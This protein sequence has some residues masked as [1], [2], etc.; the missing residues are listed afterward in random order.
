MR[1]PILNRSEQGG[2]QDEQKGYY[3]GRR[4]EEDGRQGSK[5]PKWRTSK[6]NMWMLAV[7]PVR[8][9][10]AAGSNALCLRLYPLRGLLVVVV[11]VVVVAVV[12]FHCFF[13]SL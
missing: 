6:W 11:V 4:W 7:P 10:V 1:K 12:V 9:T 13:L 5:A 2:Q 8:P 3:G